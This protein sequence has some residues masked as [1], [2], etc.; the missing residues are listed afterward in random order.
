MNILKDVLIDD[1]SDIIL[2]YVGD[3]TEKLHKECPEYKW[4]VNKGY[5]T[6]EHIKLIIEHGITKY[7]RKS[8]SI[9]KDYM[10]K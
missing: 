8:F 9:C 1:L 7:H 5:C 3:D 6:P 2:K 10:S 4:N